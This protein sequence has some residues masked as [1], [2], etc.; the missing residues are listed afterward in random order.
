MALTYMLQLMDKFALAYATLLGIIADTVSGR[1][2]ILV[3]DSLTLTT[4]TLL[5]ANTLGPL[6]YS[7]LAI[8]SG[9]PQH[10]I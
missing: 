1:T 4:R 7:T 2:R 9:P 10:P 8:L 6:R 5:A 3:D